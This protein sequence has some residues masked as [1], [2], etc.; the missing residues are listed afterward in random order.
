MSV[1]IADITFARVEHDA[2]ADLLYLHVSDPSTAV[3]FDETR[4]SRAPIRR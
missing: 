3:D 2:G 4:G 1:T